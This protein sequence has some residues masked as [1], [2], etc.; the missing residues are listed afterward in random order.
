MSMSDTPKTIEIL[1]P[2]CSRCKETYR[3]VQHVVESAGLSCQVIKNE[4][5]NRMIELGL[6]ASPG[7][8]FDGRVV[9]SGHI[10]KTEEVKQLLGIA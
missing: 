8:V 5:I 7:V 2:G 4:S 3:V 9:I 1:G 6:M 10:P